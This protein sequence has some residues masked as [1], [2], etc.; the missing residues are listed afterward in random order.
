MTETQNKS[1]RKLWIGIAALVI[2]IAALIGIYFA[3]GAK[4]TSGFKE[5]T[6]EV[7]DDEGAGTLYKTKTDAEYLR[8]AMEETEGL[9]FSGTDSAE[10]GLM[11]D[12]VNGLRADYVQ[13]NAYWSFYVNEEYCNYGVD[14]QPVNDGDAFQIIYTP[15]E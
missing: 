10:Y 1:S 8:Q 11:I 3:F 14:S 9:T 12:T 13:D 4:P 6:I 15:A 5:L 2:V 7:I